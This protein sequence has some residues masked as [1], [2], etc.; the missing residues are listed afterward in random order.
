M[1]NKNLN[2]LTINADSSS[3]K[4]ALYEKHDR[5]KQIF[6]AKIE[7]IGL[8]DTAFIITQEDKKI[9]EDIDTSSFHKA[10]F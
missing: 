1:E 3:I 2:I 9:K 8:K 7:P 6:A 10:I 4:F 5:L